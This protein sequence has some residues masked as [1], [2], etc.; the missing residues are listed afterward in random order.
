MDRNDGTSGGSLFDQQKV[1]LLAFADD[2]VVLED[3]EVDVPST[4]EDIR[5]FW[6]DVIWS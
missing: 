6:N 4:L 5:A 2:L 3:R 1:A